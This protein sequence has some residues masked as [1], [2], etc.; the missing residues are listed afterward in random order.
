MK[1]KHAFLRATQ[2]LARC[3]PVVILKHLNV[4]ARTQCGKRGLQYRALSRGF[5]R[6]ILHTFSLQCSKKLASTQ[7]CQIVE[8]RGGIVTATLESAENRPYGHFRHSSF[9]NCKCG[10]RA[11]R[12]KNSLR[13]A[14]YI[15]ALFLYFI[16]YSRKTY[17][18]I[19]QFVR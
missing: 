14:M 1:P 4:V 12:S 13:F 8:K 5:T 15:H 19:T 9:I 11:Y 10:Q 7:T 18:Q 2:R 17:C 16:T 3:N 6:L